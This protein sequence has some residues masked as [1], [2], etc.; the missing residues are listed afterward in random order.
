[1]S[2][3]GGGAVGIDRPVVE[4]MF[5]VCNE[6]LG[7]NSIP[8]HNK[9]LYKF[10][11]QSGLSDKIGPDDRHVGRRVNMRYSPLSSVPSTATVQTARQALLTLALQQ[12]Q[13]GKV[14]SQH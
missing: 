12:G 5:S 6:A 1:M 3:G 4:L 2:G 8:T 14:G 7:T 13:G 11:Q 9:T 10:S